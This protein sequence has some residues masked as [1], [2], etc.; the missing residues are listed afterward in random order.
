MRIIVLIVAFASCCLEIVAQGLEK[1]IVEEYYI[2]DSRDVAAGGGRLKEGSV[3][4]RIFVDMKPGYRLQAVFGVENHEMHISTTTGFYN[5]PM[6]GA[7]MPNIIPERVL[8]QDLVMIDS[9]LTMG[10]A[11]EFSYGVLKSADDSTGTIFN[12]TK[13]EPLLQNDAMN[14]SPAPKHRDGLLRIQSEVPRIVSFGLDSLVRY[15]D[16][17]SADSSGVSFRTDNGSWACLNGATGP[18]DSNIVLIAQLTTDGILSF[19]LNIQLISENGEVEQFVARNP[20]DR[21]WEVKSL[22]YKSE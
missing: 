19:E 21:Q 1:V 18:T 12:S 3:T 9:W 14:A 16:K 22:V 5:H 15:F 11:S 20:G 4:Y 2:A 6:Y 17:T 7:V 8:H 10:A 13:P